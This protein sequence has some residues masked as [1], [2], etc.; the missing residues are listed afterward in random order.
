MP[1]TGI[2]AKS[3]VV[4]KKGKRAS[5]SET[6]KKARK[7][8]FSNRASTK[9]VDRGG[10]VRVWAGSADASYWKPWSTNL[11]YTQKRQRPSGADM[12]EKIRKLKWNTKPAT[13]I[14]GPKTN[15]KLVRLKPRKK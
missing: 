4:S 11:K 15:G 10:S 12:A 13:A 7:A 9:W 2:K 3:R 14:K 1:K 6:N 8:R 5:P